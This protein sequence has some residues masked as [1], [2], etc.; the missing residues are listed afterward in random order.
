M[1][2]GGARGRGGITRFCGVNVGMLVDA[3]EVKGRV[4]LISARPSRPCEG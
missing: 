2:V 3:L 4:L 1:G